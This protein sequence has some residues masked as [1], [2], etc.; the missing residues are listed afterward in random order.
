MAWALALAEVDGLSVGM[1][2]KSH[3]AT[4]G[5][6]PHV[7]IWRD[8]EGGLPA[9]EL[10]VRVQL[11]WVSLSPGPSQLERSRVTHC[12]AHILTCHDADTQP[13]SYTD[14][15]MQIS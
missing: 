2:F 12:G 3:V 4:R 13:H 5:Y 14:S 10:T 7:M 9:V 8:A 11:D 6:G 1:W 15:D